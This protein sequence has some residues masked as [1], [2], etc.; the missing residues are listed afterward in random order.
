MYHNSR[1]SYAWSNGCTQFYRCK[2]YIIYIFKIVCIYIT[3]CIRCRSSTT[4]YC[5]CHISVYFVQ[6]ICCNTIIFTT[7][8]NTYCCYVN[9]TINNIILLYTILIEVYCCCLIAYTHMCKIVIIIIIIC[10]HQCLIRYRERQILSYQSLWYTNI[11][12]CNI[13]IRATINL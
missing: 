7:C 2:C 6:C 13:S 9:F 5:E 10:L 4:T 3:S 1:S 8:I 11:C 12:S